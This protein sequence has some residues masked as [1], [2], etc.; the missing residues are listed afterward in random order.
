[1]TLKT[2]DLALLRWGCISC[3]YIVVV[4]FLSHVWLFDILWTAAHQASLSFTVSWSLLKLMSIESI[5]LSNYLI[6]CHP[7]ILLPQ[8]FPASGS[9]PVSWL[10]ASDSQSIGVSASASVLPIN[11][12]DWFLWGLTGL[13]PLQSKGLSMVFFNTTVQKHQFFGAQLSLWSNSHILHDYWKNDIFD[14][15]D[16]CE[17]S[18]ASAF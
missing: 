17:Q 15:M 10:F 1:M 16:L 11:T 8:S 12:Q 4:Q 5:T 13:I 18:L 2:P 14:Y 7:L 3:S 9:F 6:L